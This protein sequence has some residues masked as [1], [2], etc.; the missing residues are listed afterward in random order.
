MHLKNDRSTGRGA[1]AWK[2]TTVRVM[3]ASRS[4]VSFCPD[5]STIPR[6]Y[7]WLFVINI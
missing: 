5:G 6:N 3:V 1:V 2:G 7:G 4:K